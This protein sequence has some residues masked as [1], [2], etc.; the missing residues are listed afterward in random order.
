MMVCTSLI[1]VDRWYY[2]PLPKNYKMNNTN[3][4]VIFMGE[5]DEKRYAY[6]AVLSDRKGIKK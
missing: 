6:E 3:M 5:R 1:N 4:R 2:S